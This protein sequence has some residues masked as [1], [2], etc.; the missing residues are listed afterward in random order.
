MVGLNLSQMNVL[1]LHEAETAIEQGYAAMKD[2]L[3]RVL[4]EC[5]TFS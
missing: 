4:V 2:H 3:P 5:R 1:A